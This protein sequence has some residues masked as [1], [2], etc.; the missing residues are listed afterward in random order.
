MCE[1]KGSSAAGWLVECDIE[2]ECLFRR[3]TKFQLNILLSLNI[4]K[5]VMMFV[6][7]C[8]G[9]ITNFSINIGLIRG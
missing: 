3:S 4:Y 5:H 2:A 1:V 9:D 7:T 6:R 8:D